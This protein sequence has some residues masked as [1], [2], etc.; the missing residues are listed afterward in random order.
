[1]T[2][3]YGEKLLPETLGAGAAFLDL[4][5][6][7]VL[8]IFFVNSSYWPGHVPPGAPPAT[9]RLYRGRGDGAFEDV[10]AAA[11]AGISLYGMGCAVAD[12]D[13]DGDDDIYVTAVGDN[14]LL[15]ND[16]GV[17]RDVTSTARVA[18]GRWR[19]R[20]GALHPEWSTA[21]AWA[22]FDLDGDLDLFVTGYVEWSPAHEIFTSLDGV[23]KTFTTPD[24]YTGLPCRLYRNRGDGTFEDAVEV[25]G[26]EHGKSLGVALWDFNED[27][28]VDV[29]VANDTR[30]NFL[31]LSRG[32]GGFEER[33]LELGVA[34]DASGRARAGMGIDIADHANDGVPAVAI[35]NF[36]AE[37]MSLYRWEPPAGFVPSAERA[38]LA[39]ATYS[40]LTFGLLFADVDLD[41]LQ[42]LVVANGHIEPDIARFRPEERHAQ[43]PQLFRGLAGGRF[44]EVT[45]AAGPDFSR[46][47]V[48][49]GLAAGDID[50][51]GDLDLLFTRNGGA[52]VLLRNDLVEERHFLR[53]RL[54]GRGRNTR[55]IGAA[56]QVRAGGAVQTRLVRTGSSYL[57]QSEMTLTFGLG[58]SGS[59][60]RIDVR[61]P[62]G[63]RGEYP[64]EAIDRTL[65]I[66]E[67]E[68]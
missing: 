48:G 15:A 45:A 26:G 12:Y 30:P 1:V 31:F 49:R 21:A 20:S 3:G 18:G 60:D 5:G 46:P 56:V 51:D 58:T 38:G 54:E 68:R 40:P 43:S 50:G 24:R 39:Q 8:D 36:S 44:E 52:P 25:P 61:W 16:G 66:R 19:D 63:G 28:F 41:G 65:E 47:I 33:G 34:Y 53:L 32:D 10:T 37:S 13:G 67:V 23:R 27:G 57:S 14:V 7:R 64:V 9:C 29:V 55:A 22:D 11:G 42:D 59:V 62:G 17:L 6:D 35:G 2:G 4:D